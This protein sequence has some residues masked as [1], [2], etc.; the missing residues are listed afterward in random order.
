ME[1]VGEKGCAWGKGEGLTT[2]F[3]I[4]KRFPGLGAFGTLVD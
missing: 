3:D 2:D 4:R 1:S